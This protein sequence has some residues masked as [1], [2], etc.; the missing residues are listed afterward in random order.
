[1]RP[2]RL[3]GVSMMLIVGTVRIGE[4]QQSRRTALLN[5][6]RALESMPSPLVHAPEGQTVLRL[7][8]ELESAAAELLRSRQLMGED[9]VRLARLRTRLDSVMLDLTPRVDSL[10]RAMAPRIDSLSRVIAPRLDSLSRVMTP[11]LDSLMREVSP[12]MEI[13]IRRL[14]PEIAGFTAQAVRAADSSRRL[15][16]VQGQTLA[17]SRGH[18]GLAM[19]G[20]QV[21]TVEP[22]GV[23]TSHCEYPLVESVEA[24][25]PAERAG[26]MTGDTVVAYNGRDVQRWAVNYPELLVPGDTVRV[27]VRRAGRAAEMPVVVA[28]RPSASSPLKISADTLVVRALDVTGRPLPNLTLVPRPEANA[29]ATFAG[30]EFATMDE[31][32]FTNLRLKPGVLVLRVPQGTP[33]AEAGLRSGDV[34]R[35]INDVPVRDAVVLRRALATA[36]GPV[37]LTVQS[38]GAKDRTI[39]FSRR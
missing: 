27:R 13:M 22:T 18:L 12:R 24:R 8:R 29:L 30:A 21:R 31:E 15:V 9:A 5:V 4:A 14:Q 35:Q 1:M 33:A 25:S 7:R 36:S 20:A 34:V 3:F 26:I 17:A 38:R 32:F 10:S 19:S 16:V 28:V 39:V 11:R 37:R 6:C 2:I 23:Y